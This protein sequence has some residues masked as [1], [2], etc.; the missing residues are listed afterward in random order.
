MSRFYA[1]K[2]AKTKNYFSFSLIFKSNS[3][4]Y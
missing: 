4:E 2:S 3:Y 1:Q